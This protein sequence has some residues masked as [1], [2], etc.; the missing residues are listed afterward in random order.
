M[1]TGLSCRLVALVAKWQ[2]RKISTYL[3]TEEEAGEEGTCASSYWSRRERPAVTPAERD[4]QLTPPLGERVPINNCAMHVEKRAG[5]IHPP[6][7]SVPP[8]S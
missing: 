5:T 1:L 3:R 2:S 8:I 6:T 7:Y 4:M